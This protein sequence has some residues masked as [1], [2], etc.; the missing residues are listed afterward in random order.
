[1]ELHEFILVLDLHE[2]VEH[3][4]VAL[5][6]IGNHEVQKVLFPSHKN[7]RVAKVV[8]IHE[9]RAPLPRQSKHFGVWPD[10]LDRGPYPNDGW[11][12][13]KEAKYF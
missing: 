9:V 6:P 7:L 11:V 1:M 2:K 10:W 13:P 12:E 3:E 5:L 4:K 8:L